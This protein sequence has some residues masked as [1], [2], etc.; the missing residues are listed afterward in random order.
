METENDKL[1][2]YKEKEK[3]DKDDKDM[4]ELLPDVRKQTPYYVC[5]FYHFH[6]VFMYTK[7]KLSLFLLP[8]RIINPSC[9]NRNLKFR[10]SRLFWMSYNLYCSLFQLQGC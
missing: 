6:S 10:I 7:I 2:N 8:K 5:V 3:D 4:V 9:I 1:E